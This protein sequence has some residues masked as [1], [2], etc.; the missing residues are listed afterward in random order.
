VTISVRQAAPDDLDAIV[1]LLGALHDP[2]RACADADSWGAMLDQ[3]GRTILLAERDGD[4]VG[5]AD[6]WIAPTLLNGA[7]PRAFVNYVAVL[8]SARRSGV[9]RALM[10]EAH[11]RATDAGCGDVLLL[12]G[13][14][15]PDAHRFYAAIGYERCAIGLRKQLREE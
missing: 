5:T 10:E 2:S 3:T 14:H 9:G 4:P 11:R 7:A 12:S 1:M 8:A 13:D 6:L 15:R